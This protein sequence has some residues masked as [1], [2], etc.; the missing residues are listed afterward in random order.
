[1]IG[2]SPLGSALDLTKPSCW[3][4]APSK[5][6]RRVSLTNAQRETAAGLELIT[7]CRHIT[8]DGRLSEAEIDDLRGWVSAFGDS[9]LPAHAHLDATLQRVLA[10]GTI[11]PDERREVYAAIEKVVPPDVRADV[12]ARRKRQDKVEQEANSPLEGWDFMV[13][14]CR[15]EGRGAVIEV[16]CHPSDRVFLV[17][18]PENTHSRNAVEVRLANGDQIGYVPEMDAHD[19]APLLDAAY[20][21]RA[22]IKKVLTGGRSPIP[23]VVADFYGHEAVLDD[24]TDPKDSPVKVAAAR[25]C[26]M[27][28]AVGLAGLGVAIGRLLLT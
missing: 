7:L 16:Y 12:V 28:L 18:D 4:M 22:R 21:Y 13:A 8:D 11:T 19:M 3:I 25:G 1:M 15:Y 20:R 24:L 5:Q 27:L 6:S 2:R 26:A 14:G 23:V 17:R 10:D 9:S